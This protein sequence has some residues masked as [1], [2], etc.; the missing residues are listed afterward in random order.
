MDI[1]EGASRQKM[2]WGSGDKR[3][4]IA[5]WD[6]VRIEDHWDPVNTEAV[7]GP[8]ARHALTMPFW[9]RHKDNELNRTAKGKDRIDRDEE[10]RQDKRARVVEMDTGDGFD[11]PAEAKNEDEQLEEA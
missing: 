5:I 3:E 10:M 1:P 2:G 7:D 11:K 6:G 4:R 8:H 9:V